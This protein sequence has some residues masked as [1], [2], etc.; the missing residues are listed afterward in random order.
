MAKKKKPVDKRP[1]DEK[2]T[3]PGPRDFSQRAYDAVR[4]VE[5]GHAERHK[6]DR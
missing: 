5:K 6:D 3:K 2:S 4:E 1:N